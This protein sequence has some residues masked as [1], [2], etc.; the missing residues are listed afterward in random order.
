MPKQSAG[1]LCYRK[2]KGQLMV[3]LVH[4][5][6]PLWAKRDA[7]AWSIPKGGIHEDEEPLEAARREF[8][9]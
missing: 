1:I 7:G 8:E 2:V 3:L 6:G 5:G 9:E 4:H